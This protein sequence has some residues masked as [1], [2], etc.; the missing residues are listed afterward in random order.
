MSLDPIGTWKRAWAAAVC[1]QSGQAQPCDSCC[2]EAR[3]RGPCGANPKPKAQE[4]E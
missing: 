4:A 2:P 3:G 1:S